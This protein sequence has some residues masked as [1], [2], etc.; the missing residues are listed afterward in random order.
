VPTFLLLLGGGLAYLMT[1]LD[2]LFTQLEFPWLFSV[3]SEGAQGLLTAIASSVLGV[4]GTTFTITIAVLTLTSQQYGPRLLRTFLQDTRNQV[5][6]G[7][8]IGTFLYA[9]LVMGMV[10]GGDESIFVPRL[11]VSSA[12]ETAESRDRLQAEFD[13][14]VELLDARK[15]PS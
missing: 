13:L 9:L 5:V 12:L 10:R 14:F 4:A 2:R 8:L 6:L 7:V 11:A 3:G 15:L 1:W